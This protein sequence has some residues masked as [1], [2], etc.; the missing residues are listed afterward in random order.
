MIIQGKSAHVK[1][2]FVIEF[3]I[4]SEIVGESQKIKEA[5]QALW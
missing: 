4:H 2:E 3:V 1:L 5:S